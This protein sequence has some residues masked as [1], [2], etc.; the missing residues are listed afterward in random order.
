[1]KI[2]T[3]AILLGIT[4]LNA[5]CNISSEYIEIEGT[6]RYIDLEAGFWGITAGDG[7]NFD[8]LNLP[9]EYKKDG[10]KVVVKLQP[11]DELAG[12]HMWGQIVEI[13]EIRKDK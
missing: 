8:P 5:S 9:E 10:L 6:I 2:F 7:R 13:K 12:L 3:L 4:L 11:K 1:M